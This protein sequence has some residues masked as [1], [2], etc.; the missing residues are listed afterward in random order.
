MTS[1]QF[2][3]LAVSLSVQVALVIIV[4]HWLG[5]LVNSERMQCRLWTVCYVVLLSL[6]GAALLL[7]HPRLFQPW[8]SIGAQ[9]T[10]TLVTIEM[11]LGQ[12]LFFVWLAGASVSLMV[13]F[14]RSFQVNRFLNTCQPLDLDEFVSEENQLDIPELTSFPSK[15]RLRLLTSTR[16]TTPFCSQ[17]HY[18][19]IVVPEYLLGF[20]RQKLN[21]IIRHE[22]EHLKT[23][24]PLQL[25]LQRVVEVI[26][27]FHPMVWWASQQSSISREFAC[28]EAAI[29]SPS[30]IVMYL[31]TLLTIMEYSASQAEETPTSLAFGRGKSI[32]AKRAR[33]LT[34]IAKRKKI[35]RRARILGPAACFSLVM[36]ATLIG[37]LWLPI[38]VLAS[39]RTNWSPWPTWSAS[40]LHDFDIPARDFEVFDHRIEL[41]ELLEHQTPESIDDD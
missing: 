39:S 15:Q 34:Q 41:H 4:A 24:H 11:Q 27:W 33:R 35:D 29:D 32:V 25:F 14:F 26:F 13:F 2:L 3:E 16:L 40:I 31:Q 17:F 10:T 6:I 37:F 19:Y 36:L 28:D 18:P 23:G 38:D 21:F 7:P 1:T 22:L 9:H 20:D 8:D 12:I 30:D 5:R